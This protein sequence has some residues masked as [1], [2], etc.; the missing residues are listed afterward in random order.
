MSAAYRYP[1]D[2]A[3][4]ST[5]KALQERKGSRAAYRRVEEGR[6]WSTR[7]TPDL[8]RFV[9]EQTS[10]FLATANSAGQPHVQ[11]RGGPPGFLHVL[12]ET[13]I[14]FVDFKGNRQYITQGNLVENSKALLLLIDYSQRRRVKLWGEALVVEGDHDLTA[15]LM[16]GQ[17]EARAEQVLIFTV[18]AWDSNC[19]RHIPRR[20]D[21]AEVDAEIEARD[22][23]IR[24]LERQLARLGR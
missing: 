12:D 11:H 14:A 24:E 20:Y 22:Q 1:S 18:F 5:V 6:P 9:S 8:A 17:Y 16:P 15:A 10:V 2:V 23:R 13:T 3:F 7:L 19:P 4:T 21:A